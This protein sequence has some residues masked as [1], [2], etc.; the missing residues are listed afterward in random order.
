MSGFVF[1]VNKCAHAH[2]EI[3]KNMMTTVYGS[4]KIYSTLLTL[5]KGSLLPSWHMMFSSPYEGSVTILSLLLL[6]SSR[7]SKESFTNRKGHT[8]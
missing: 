4:T 8:T 3:G 1:A 6:T 2:T 5:K 7:S